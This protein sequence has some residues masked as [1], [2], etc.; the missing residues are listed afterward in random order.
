IITNDKDF[1]NLIFRR[2]NEHSGVIFLRLKDERSA[3]K[4]SVLEKL[5]SSLDSDF[6]HKFITVSE[7]SIRISS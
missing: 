6:G 1:G 7:K 4:I 3:N 2:K 5:F